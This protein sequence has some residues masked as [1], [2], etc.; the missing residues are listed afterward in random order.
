M[1]QPTR[2]R[3]RFAPSPTGP[4]HF[5]SLVAAMA[6]YLDAQAHQGDWLL[7]IEDVDETRSIRGAA[8]SIL[9]TL[10][11]LGFCW[12][13]T[14]L[15]QSHRKT[16]YREIIEF[17]KVEG[18][19]Y[20]CGCSR[21]EIAQQGK[22]GPEGHIYP[23]TCRAGLASGKSPRTV[24]FQSQSR[25]IGFEDRIQGPISQQM[26]KELG[27]F[28]IRRADGYTAY[29]LAVVLDDADQ[30]ITHVVRGADLLMSTPRQILL[31]QALDLR[32]PDYAHVPLALG[33][34]GKKLSKQDRADPVH[35]LPAVEVLLAAYRF[36]RQDA[37]PPL[38]GSVEEFW[39]WAIA[40][41][42]VEPLAVKPE[43]RHVA[44]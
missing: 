21:T 3:G 38:P 20:D 7:R 8:D 1:T 44:P 29:Q 32:Q 16:Y 27:D 25:T 33:A 6:S 43:T 36:L 12:D 19:A 31:Q 10:D 13:G 9:H 17:L 37:T 4:L 35:A 23:G 26:A 2:Y 24:R 11:K 18:L 14:I 22:L 40:H 41:W 42:S 28:V 30:R 5:G 39:P 34:D 15:T